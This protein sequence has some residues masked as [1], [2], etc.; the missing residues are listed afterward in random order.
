MISFNKK[1]SILLKILSAAAILLLWFSIEIPRGMW[2]EQ[3]ER[4]EVAHNRMISM[5]EL[6]TIY[7]Q[8]SGHFNNNVKEVYDYAVN[9]DTLLVGAPEIELEIM[10]LDTSKIRIS[11][12]D[13]DRV[14]D[15]NVVRTD[16]VKLKA[17]ES[18]AVKANE[19]LYDAGNEIVVSLKMRDKNLN[20]YSHQIKVSSLSGIE[21]VAKYKGAKDIYWDFS[22]K[23]GKLTFEKIIIPEY[24]EQRVNMARYIL[25]NF[26]QDKTPYL[27]P[28]TNDPFRVIFNLNAKIYLKIGFFRDENKDESLKNQPVLN[29]SENEKVRNYFLNIANLKAERRVNDLVREYEMDADSTYSSQ[30]AKDSLFA[31]YFKNYLKTAAI[32]KAVTDSISKNLSATDL[33]QDT[34]F[35][36]EKRFNTLF[37]LNLPEKVV[38]QLDDQENMNYINTIKCVYKTGIV[39]IDTVSVR[40]ESPINEKSVFKGYKRTF[41]QKYFGVEDDQNHG[42]VDNN[43]PSWKKE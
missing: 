21:A 42:F 41:L 43:R 13:Y 15:L 39:N 1:G 37:A 10:T 19:I 18:N 23:S 34:E 4:E 5:S 27:C 32:K 12:N 17:I 30:E 2:L 16:G 14:A 7:M 22:A 31:A 8:E 26:D 29:I 40:I 11:F 35:S 3:K 36:E 28:S 25:N 24:E 33:N 9:F 20:L 38:K 6:E